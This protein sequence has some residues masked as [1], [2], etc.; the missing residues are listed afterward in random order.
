M[1]LTGFF[2]WMSEFNAFYHLYNHPFY[3]HSTLTLITDRRACSNAKSNTS[4]SSKDG[5]SSGGLG[6]ESKISIAYFDQLQDAV[7]KW[8]DLETRLEPRITIH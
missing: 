6:R 1:C 2:F 5:C 7:D 4:I 3:R 8:H